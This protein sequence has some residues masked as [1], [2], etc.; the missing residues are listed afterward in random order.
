[1]RYLVGI[2][3]TVFLYVEVEANSEEEAA[4]LANSK[5]ISHHS[6][7]FIGDAPY[8]PDYDIRKVE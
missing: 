3:Y 6:M 8:H 2:P 7:A 4:D 1:M 5:N